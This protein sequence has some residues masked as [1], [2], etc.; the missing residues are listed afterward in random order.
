MAFTQDD[1]R[2]R[3]GI[4]GQGRSGRFGDTPFTFKRHPGQRFD[5]DP[6]TTGEVHCTCDG[7]IFGVLPSALHLCHCSSAQARPA[8]CTP[9]EVT[10]PWVL[11][12]AAW[13]PGSLRR[14]RTGHSVGLVST[15]NGMR[16]FRHGLPSVM[17]R[18]HSLVIPRDPEHSP[19]QGSCCSVP[20]AGLAQR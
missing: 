13:L 12:P 8:P 7:G 4:W 3:L 1:R 9:S 5:A 17:T 11:H 6:D 19:C 10:S 2:L 20:V 16:E 15:P 14:T 18:R